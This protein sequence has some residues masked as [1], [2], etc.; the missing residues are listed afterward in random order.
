MVSRDI[1]SRW[2]RSTSPSWWNF[3]TWKRRNQEQLQRQLATRRTHRN[4]Q[5][6]KGNGLR[7]PLR[8]YWQAN[9]HALLD[10]TTRDWN[11][12]YFTWRVQVDMQSTWQRTKTRKKCAWSLDE[13]IQST[14]EDLL[15]IFTESNW[16][17]NRRTRK[18]V[19]VA[20]FYL[21][22]VLLPTLTRNQNSNRAFVVWGQVRGHDNRCIGRNFFPRT[23]LSSSLEGNASWNSDAIH[24]AQ[25]HSA[26]VDYCGCK[27]LFRRVKSR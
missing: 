26:T 25:G 3:S 13:D 17:G 22:G 23:A 9:W 16:A 7:Q 24:L 20:H 14:G 10:R 1:P 15:E 12:W 21:N 18:S 5:V 6:N 4:W 27:N 8:C 19:S 11:T 2:E